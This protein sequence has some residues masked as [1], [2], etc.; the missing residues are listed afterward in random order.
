TPT[1][2]GDV[3]LVPQGKHK[4]TLVEFRRDSVTD[5]AGHVCKQPSYIFSPNH[6]NPAQPL[7][8]I[9]NTPFA[10]LGINVDQTTIYWL[11]VTCPAGSTQTLAYMVLN[12]RDMIMMGQGEV[13]GIMRKQ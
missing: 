6:V 1:E 13:T 12:T 2:G 10:K 5:G 4:S 11:E 3:K 9:G 8:E 7:M